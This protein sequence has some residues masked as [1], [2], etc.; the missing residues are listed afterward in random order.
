[1]STPP[2]RAC[3]A[4][5]FS[6]FAK[7][8]KKKWHFCLFRIA[9]QGVSL[10]HFHVYMYSNLLYQ[11]KFREAYTTRNVKEMLQAEGM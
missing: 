8:R 6:D 2:G 7:E 4:L 1:V 11:P 9:T 5:P 3:S 10:W